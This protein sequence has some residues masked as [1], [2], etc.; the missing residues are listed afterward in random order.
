[1]ANIATLANVA[2]LKASQATG[3][4]SSLMPSGV[5]LP[6]G[7]IAAP[8]GW[9]ECDGQEVSQTTYAEL[10]AALG[11]TYNTQLNPTT[12]SNWA[13]PAGGNFRVP[14]MRGM[15]MRGE[16]T[17]SGKDAVTLGANQTEKTKQNGMSVTTTQSKISNLNLNSSNVS[18][19]LNSSS[20]SGTASTTA[21]GNTVGAGGYALQRSDYAWEGYDSRGGVAAGRFGSVGNDS[22]T[23]ASHHEHS[24][25]VN[26]SGSITGTAAAQTVSGTPT[27]AAQT[28]QDINAFPS[29]V[30]A[31]A[32]TISSDNETRPINRG[33]KYI[34]KV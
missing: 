21:S 13:A 23:T 22:V 18:I 12:G 8:T 19:T 5:I 9:L 14:D 32:I 31:Q 25:T 1:M 30:Q 7:G 16:G 20:V 24:Y 17:P 26:S 34:I 11:T 15:F 10:Y 2:D 4:V 29:Y 28:L 27:A 3:T 33:V 6:F